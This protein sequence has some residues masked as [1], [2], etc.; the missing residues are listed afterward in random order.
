M[1]ICCDQEFPLTKIHPKE[2]VMSRYKNSLYGYKLHYS[3]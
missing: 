3:L 2:I 1:C